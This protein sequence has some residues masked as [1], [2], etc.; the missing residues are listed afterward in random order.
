MA[1]ILFHSL[2]FAPDGVSTAY[3]MTDLARELHKIGHEICVLTTTPHFNV[4]H[5]ALEKQPLQRA[6]GRWLY[7]SEL[8]GIV[9]W[10][11]A[12]PSK[13]KEVSGRI[14][15]MIRFHILSLM[16]G[17][18][19]LGHWDIVLAPSPPLTIGLI[20]WLLGMKNGA[21]SIYNVQEVYPDLAIKEGI[22]KRPN[23][24]R[25]FRWIE[26]LVYNRNSAIVVIA[27]HFRNIVENRVHEPEKV[28]VIPNF[29]DMDLY[30]VL[31]RD[32]NFS[33]QH[34]LTD[35]FVI[36]Y[37][38]N[39]GLA[40]DWDTLVYAAENLSSLLIKFLIVGD[41]AKKTWL[42]EEIERKNLKNI[43]LLDYQPR[44]I[45][46]LINASSDVT[47]ILMTENASEYG[48]PSKIYTTM[49]CGKST[50]VY[51]TIESELVSV[52]T[53][54]GC[55]RFVPIGDKEDYVKAVLDAYNSPEKLSLEG[56]KGREFIEKNFTKE[57][58]AKQFDEL[59]NELISK[60][61]K[62]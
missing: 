46:P 62:I 15:D 56:K 51:A 23:I 27:E 7:R 52:I 57:S 54:S 32:N 20:A 8:N 19:L 1:K 55:G 53:K 43:I 26:R 59:I 33:R 4:L 17:M 31:P 38:G 14:I 6:F 12:M 28:R 25:V 44:E 61:K 24:I 34:G 22:I 11:V 29:V 49:A 18:T 48:F 58:V 39:I 42:A 13:K 45:M 41:G 21:P 36:S 9:V 35:Y 3:L 60:R 37:A 10:H 50:I 16:F 5:K 47:T 2:V 40:Q 30:R